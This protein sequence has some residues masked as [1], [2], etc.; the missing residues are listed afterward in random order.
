MARVT[1]PAAAWGELRR[2]SWFAWWPVTAR[3]GRG[4]ET[5]W[6]ERVTV[7]ERLNGY[8]SRATWSRL[9]FVDQVRGD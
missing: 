4:I 2:R 7:L 5:R 8:P 3:S 9:Q 6:L 1:M